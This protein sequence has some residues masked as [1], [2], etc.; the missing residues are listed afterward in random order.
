M[1]DPSGR[2]FI[3]RTVPNGKL[4][5]SSAFGTGTTIFSK[6][7]AQ[8]EAKGHTEGASQRS[9]ENLTVGLGIV[10]ADAILFFKSAKLKILM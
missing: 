10:I 8:R 7:V 3:I 6:A 5:W 4:S 2:V 1:T 9:G